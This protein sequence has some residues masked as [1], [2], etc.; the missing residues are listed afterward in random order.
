MWCTTASSEERNLTQS[1]T[2]S[3]ASCSSSPSTHSSARGL[4][5]FGAQGGFYGTARGLGLA[6]ATKR[7]RP[8]CLWIAAIVLPQTRRAALALRSQHSRSTGEPPLC[9]SA[10]KRRTT[11][12]SYS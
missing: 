6:S 2:M 11:A 7:Q 5:G 9:S 10:C 4:G 12:A 8:S 1:L 3:Q